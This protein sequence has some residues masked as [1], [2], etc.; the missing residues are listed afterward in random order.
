MILSISEVVQVKEVKN[1]IQIQI[2]YNLNPVAKPPV[3]YSPPGIALGFTRQE[4]WSE[5]PFP[6]AGNP[7]PGIELASPASPA[8]QANSLP[9]EPPGKPRQYKKDKE[10]I[11]L[12]M[13]LE[14][15][16][17]FFL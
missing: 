12:L 6:T 13:E 9:T 16:S 17:F 3:D 2:P 7:D 5:L 8:L 10:F 1:K 14:S 11:E 15:E 4:Y